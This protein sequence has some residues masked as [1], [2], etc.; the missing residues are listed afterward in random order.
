MFV[1]LDEYIT[2]NEEDTRFEAHRECV[3]IQYLVYVKNGLE[4]TIVEVL[5][6]APKRLAENVFGIS[7]NTTGS[8]PIIVDEKGTLL[9]RET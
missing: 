9:L 3:D 1:N 4:Y 6:L 2:K 7:V 8:T 5:K